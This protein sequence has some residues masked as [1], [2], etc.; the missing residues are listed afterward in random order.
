MGNLIASPLAASPQVVHSPGNRRET[1]DLSQ[2][3]VA[4]DAVAMPLSRKIARVPRNVS[5][6]LGGSISA[7]KTTLGR[8]LQLAAERLGVPCHFAPETVNKDALHLYCSGQKMPEW[9]EKALRNVDDEKTDVVREDDD[10]DHEKKEEEPDLILYNCAFFDV[11]DGENN[12]ESENNAATVEQLRQQQNVHVARDDVVN[13]Y[14]TAFQILML[15]DCQHRVREAALFLALHPQGLAISDRTPWDNTVFEEA[16]R[17]LYRSISDRDHEF[18][19]LV[20]GSAPAFGVDALLFLDVSVD[21]T[22][23]RIAVRGSSAEA[24][25]Q[26]T[27]MT[28][29][30]D[31]WFHR[32]V[33]NY[34]TTPHYSLFDGTLKSGTDS[35][36]PIVVVPWDQ[37][38]NHENLFVEQ[39]VERV[40][41]C[42]ARSA[43]TVFPRI[44]FHKSAHGDKK[45]ET[46]NVFDWSA[47]YADQRRSDKRTEFKKKVMAKLARNES[48]K[49]LYTRA[50]Q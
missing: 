3:H 36:F 2:E 33:Q 26:R 48:I 21:E 9:Y 6:G 43:Q 34:T 17:S 5:I 27:Y 15:A 13:E 37:F 40:C 19:Q 44:S 7:G 8:A 49:F 41:E 35:P 4:N 18:Y 32:V 45:D 39:M 20:R 30:H 25:Y 31:I 10:D 16:N 22:M 46:N 12:T 23:R 14:A 42:V 28:Y 24:R 1:K 38:E 50:N 47:D 29:L 11:D